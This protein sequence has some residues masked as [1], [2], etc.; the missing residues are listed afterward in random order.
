MCGIF[1][2]TDRALVA[3]EA[4]VERC[5]QRRGTETVV[6][7][8]T[9]SGCVLAHC[10]LPVR[11][12]APVLQPLDLDDGFLL[13]SG[14]LWDV[15]GGRS[16]SIELADRIGAF[17][18]KR[19]VERSRGMWALVMVDRRRREMSFC[20]DVMGEQPLHYGV[21]GRHIAVASEVKTLVAA[22][23]P[24]AGISHV[25]P[26]VL[27]RFAGTLETTRYTAAHSRNRWRTFDVETLRG[28]IA[29]AVRSHVESIDLQ[30]AGVL[31][32][33]GI[34]ST[35][36]A[37]HASQFGIRKAWTVAVHR[38]V[39][40]AVAAGQIADR[41]GLEWECVCCE[42]NPIEL[43]VVA[44][45]VVNR[46]ILEESCLHIAL[47]RHLSRRG[48]RVVLTGSGADELFVGYAHLLRR[49]PK[50]LLQQRFV[51]EYFK[52]DL[53]AMN[54]VYGGRAVEIR[55]PFLHPAVVRYALQLH[56]TVLVG[57][58][59]VLKW[60][61]RKA[62][63][64]ILDGERAGPKRIARETMGAK[65]WFAARYPEGGRVFHPLWKDIMGDPQRVMRILSMIDG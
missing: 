47:A 20:T 8:S 57:P 64:D 62:Y 26:G 14:E 27:Y 43:G 46:S 59:M 38:D 40:D 22:G 41:L 15:G 45:E 49:M 12:K 50:E 61:L 29:G 54:K 51:N 6:W 28:R 53:R 58:K 32:S 37:W 19:A 31:L 1:A 39:P 21:V 63:A 60:P 42:P 44:A 3:D 5:L 24:L 7:R 16:D 4:A 35:I 25:Q 56:A 13:Y 34:D 23:V 33:G 30:E 9:D 52:L 2:T 18:L 36:I 48:I 17:G 10:L 65:A 55:N 11:G